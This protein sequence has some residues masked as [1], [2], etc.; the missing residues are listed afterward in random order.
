M[1]TQ[2]KE[3]ILS[4]IIAEYI[5]TG[6][7]VSSDTVARKGLGVSSATIRND[8]N[9]LEEFGYLSQPHTSAGRIPSDKGYR[10]YIGSLMGDARLSLADQ[11][12]IRHQ[13]HQVRRE[14]EQWTHLAAAILSSM[15]HNVAI[16]TLPK[17]YEPRLKHV[18]LVSL[19]EFLALLILILKEARL[20][21]HVLTLENA[22]TQ[23]ELSTI[24]QKINSAFSGLNS[25]EISTN[26]MQFSV[27]EEQIVKSVI[28]LLQSE[29]EEPYED[30][31]IDG[32]R[33]ILNQPEF[34]SNNK[35]AAVIEL[36]EQKRL[37]KSLLPQVLTEDG[38]QV[39]IGGENEQDIMRDF[40]VIIS[41]Y[42][43]PGE[44]SGAIGVIGPTRIQY[45]RAIPTV[46]FLSSVMS[47]LL[48]ELYR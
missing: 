6:L 46:Y 7:P 3:Y 42:G 14:V 19:Q 16:V 30:P 10:H 4:I 25:S 18:E 13:F 17:P 45:N 20:K 23:E 31:Y 27:T 39:F 36:F 11:F 2:R 34:S 12:M 15:V 43:I 47:E 26:D 5:H 22:T 21:Q 29:E 1:L 38:V 24:A 33:H 44:V 40:S 35:L 32:L 37:L 41:K 48:S 8:M 28:Q 9:E